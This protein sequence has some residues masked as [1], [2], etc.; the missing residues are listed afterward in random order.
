MPEFMLDITEEDYESAGSKFI[1]FPLPLVKGATQFRKVECGMLDWDTPG[2]SM[3]IP[4][5]IIEQG[6]DKEKDEKLSFGVDSKGIW[7]GKSIYKNIAGKD[8]PMKVGSDKKS[9]PAP[10]T[11]DINGKEAV[12]MWQVVEGKKGGVGE[13]ILY[14]KLIDILP[15]GYKPEVAKDIM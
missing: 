10:K 15:K 1:T 12:G 11:E 4:V 5:T 8:M 9:H 14:P 2:K 6:E 3:K 13:A 7:K